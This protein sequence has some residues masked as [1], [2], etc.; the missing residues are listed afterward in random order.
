MTTSHEEEFRRALEKH[1]REQ[2]AKAP[3]VLRFFGHGGVGVVQLLGHAACREGEEPRWRVQHV[4][5]TLYMQPRS[6]VPESELAL[7]C[8]YETAAGAFAALDRAL[9]YWVKTLP[10]AKLKDLEVQIELANNRHYH[11]WETFVRNGCE[12][13]GKDAC[14]V[15]RGECGGVPGNENI[16]DGKVMCDYCHAR[17]IENRYTMAQIDAAL[18]AVLGEPAVRVGKADWHRPHAITQAAGVAWLAKRPED[19]HTRVLRAAHRDLEMTCQ[20]QP[21]DGVWPEN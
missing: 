21:H 17:K 14:E 11:D 10:T 4:E 1:G 16:V 8:Q 9:D 7:D 5:R 19:E 3:F 2:E 13:L 6:D 20:F 18:V 12:P 15:C